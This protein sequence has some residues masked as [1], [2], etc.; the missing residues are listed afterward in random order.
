VS[1]RTHYDVAVLR[2]RR[3]LRPVGVQ[4]GSGSVMT[5]Q[6]LDVLPRP[7]GVRLGSRAGAGRS[8]TATDDGAFW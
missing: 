8:P 5:D 2:R 4:S 6:E 7:S 3:V 1:G